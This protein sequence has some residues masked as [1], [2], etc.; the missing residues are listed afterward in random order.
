MFR[1][2]HAKRPRV[3]V[4]CHFARAC[5]G[6]GQREL[7]TRAWIELSKFLSSR[8]F[9]SANLSPAEEKQLTI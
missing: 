5:S 9:A 2:S 3:P 7:L 4:Q 6:D 8:V 1:G